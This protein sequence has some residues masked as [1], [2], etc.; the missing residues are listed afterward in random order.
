M[1]RICNEGTWYGALPVVEADTAI[2]LHRIV[3]S[4]NNER[5]PGIDGDAISLRARS[6]GG[7]HGARGCDRKSCCWVDGNAVA[8]AIVWEFAPA[9]Q[10]SIRFKCHG[11]EFT[12]GDGNHTIKP[13]GDGCLTLKR[14]PPIDNCAI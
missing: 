6:G 11:I 5:M 10:R 14:F 7:G 1:L 9:Y 3:G 2:R 13:K 12:C 4:T 8:H